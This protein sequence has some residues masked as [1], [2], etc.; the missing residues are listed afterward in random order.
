MCGIESAWKIEIFCT[1]NHAHTTYSFFSIDPN[2]C[3]A[4]KNFEKKFFCDEY[5]SAFLEKTIGHMNM[6][7]SAK[8]FYFSRSFDSTWFQP[9]TT[10]LSPCRAILS[11]CIEFRVTLMLKKNTQCSKW[12]FLFAKIYEEI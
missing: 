2:C 1:G 6:V 7:A 5:V 10:I 11:S 3:S 8:N 4:K 12:D 9:H